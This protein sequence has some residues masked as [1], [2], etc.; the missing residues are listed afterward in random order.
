ML[1]IGL[2]SALLLPR[3][4]PRSEA[5]EAMRGA[6]READSGAGTGVEPG[7]TDPAARTNA[8]GPSPAGADV[9]L[10]ESHELD[11]RVEWPD[12]RP[13]PGAELWFLPPRAVGEALDDEEEL[14]RVQDDEVVVQ[15][16]GRAAVVDPDGRAHL[17]VWAEGVVCARAGEHFASARI[18]EADVHRLLRLV[19]QRDVQIE[20]Q[21]VDE[22]GTPRADVAMTLVGR[23]L[24]R[25][26]GL[27][28][29]E[30][31]SLAPTDSEG[32]TRFAHLQKRLPMPGPDVLD[33]S[34]ALVGSERV[35]QMLERAVTVEE[36]LAGRPI[37]CVVP[38]GGVVEVSVV[39]ERG[40]G[41]LEEL[42][43]Q[44]VDD[45][46]QDR[47][48]AGD[49][50]PSSVRFLDVPLAHR[51]RL[52]VQR[53]GRTLHDVA[54]VGPTQAGEVVPVSVVLPYRR[55]VLRMVVECENG[56]VAHG[57]TATVL[58]E[59]AGGRR[60]GIQ[61]GCDPVQVR[62]G[63][64]VASELWLGPGERLVRVRIVFQHPSLSDGVQV[65]VPLPIDADADLGRFVL[66]LPQAREELLRVRVLLGGA[67][68]TADARL[69]LD[70][71]QHGSWSSNV[72]E[73]VLEDGYRVLRGL[74]SPN[75]FRLVVRHPRALPSTQVVRTGDVLD[76]EL[77]PGAELLVPV[78][79]TRLPGSL[80]RAHLVGG[81]EPI[82]GYSYGDGSLT[83]S[84]VP[85]G[86]YSLSVRFDEREIVRRE[87]P[88]L[89][90]G[91]NVWPSW[92][93]PIDLDR[94]A[95]VVRLHVRSVDGSTPENW[96]RFVLPRGAVVLP[97]DWLRG[98]DPS[99]LLIDDSP[100][101]LVVWA[102]GH[103]PVRLPMPTED[104]E[105]V[106]RPA[107][108]LVVHAAG[109]VAVQFS[110]EVI[111][112]GLTDP[113]LHT[114]VEQTA[115]RPA[116]FELD[117]GTTQ[118]FEF[119]PGTELVLRVRQDNGTPREQK[120]VVGAVGPQRVELR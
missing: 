38:S 110:L 100:S 45:V 15:R 112:P 50:R 105:I 16:R 33:W 84:T 43:L 87:L 58:G 42:Q 95:R 4:E 92:D 109:G 93:E 94:L 51:W 88:P 13:A 113:L 49:R 83:W 81:G 67:V 64:Q 55:L 108:K 6:R 9:E 54:F 24:R 102:H 115:D 76:V 86:S 85:L 82:E 118:E 2:V 10:A 90:A 8:I 31:V 73:S 12:G 70:G 57:A 25:A 56:E 47:F 7:A 103:L 18:D 72:Y 41:L 106:L 37:R 74:S 68:V 99:W 28:A 96:S 91:R 20:V 35:A 119:A 34:C 14:E 77:T 32:R 80:L 62:S 30:R 22:R 78:R 71:K 23:F 116:G 120:V 40:A 52:E 44:L 29:L 97:G 111:R 69:D 59:I 39:D 21:V 101:D 114:V 117:A 26:G 61:W 27:G 48:R 17:R 65:Q 3:P 5:G 11:V 107:T 66:P 104:V 79:A 98:Q 60:D 63:E 1:A 53:A 75:G 46:T 19:L 89:V 36:L